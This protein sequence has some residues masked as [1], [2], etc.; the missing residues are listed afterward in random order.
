MTKCVC[1]YRTT[2][3]G[4]LQHNLC[5]ESHLFR[6]RANKNERKKKNRTFSTQ[7]DFGI[8]DEKSF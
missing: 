1:V 7:N 6:Q 3:K 4:A 2:L 5:I 8:S